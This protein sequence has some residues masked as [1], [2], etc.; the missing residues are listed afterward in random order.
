MT[1]RSSKNLEILFFKMTMV[2]PKESF[3]IFSQSNQLSAAS[4]ITLTEGTQKECVS[5]AGEFSAA[6]V[7]EKAENLLKASCRQ[8]EGRW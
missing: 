1:K 5:S 2:I 3:L 7:S 6:D 8:S 4:N